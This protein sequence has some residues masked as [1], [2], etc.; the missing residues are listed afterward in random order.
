MRR[1][2][3][4]CDGFAV[5]A[6]AFGLAAGAVANTGLALADHPQ[7]APHTVRLV[8]PSAAV[9]SKGEIEA[10]GGAT[11]TAWDQAARALASAGKLRATTAE[12]DGSSP[13]ARRARTD[14]KRVGMTSIAFLRS[15]VEPAAPPAVLA[16]VKSWM[17]TQID[18]LHSVNMRDWE[19]ANDAADRANALVATI[20]SEC[21]LR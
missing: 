6:A 21:G 16:P 8:P 15:K 11:C 18:R 10:A 12:P 3:S 4:H 14:E 7:P 2:R 17:A 13:E 20:V 19:A 1:R 5:A 9:Y